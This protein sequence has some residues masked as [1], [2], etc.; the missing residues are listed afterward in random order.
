MKDTLLRYRP[1]V[2]EWMK[3][4]PMHRFGREYKG[5]DCTFRHVFTEL[6]KR[7]KTIRIVE[8]GTS[9]S[10]VDGRFPGCNS[11]DTKYWEPQN[12]S[13]WDYGAGVFTYM[14]AEWFHANHMNYE[15]YTV[16]LCSNHI[17]RS[18]VMTAP[19]AQK[20]QYSVSDSVNFLRNFGTKCDLI[21]LDTGDMTPIEPTAK[22]QLAEAQVIVE[23]RLLEPGGYILIDD[24]RNPTAL[25]QGD[26]N[27]LGKAKYSVPYLKQHG[28]QIIMDEYQMLL[29][30]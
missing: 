18:K 3:S 29:T 19:F 7:N 6:S 4:I 14:C 5:R 1:Y 28:F 25:D 10:F 20:I 27:P 23:Q 15:Q 22:L 17:Q 8:L 13:K 2:D 24:V 21:Y 30:K 11:D 26:G 16:D 12:P 9:R